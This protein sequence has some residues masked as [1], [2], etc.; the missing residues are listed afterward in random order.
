MQIG[1]IKLHR[2]IL[3][4]SWS[5]QPDFVAVWVYC[6][7]RGN[8]KSTDVVTKGGG[9]V[10]LEP[11]QFIT[12]REQISLGTGVQES[13]VERVL[14]VFKSEQQIEQRNCG[15]YRVISILNWSKYQQ[16]EQEFEQCLNNERTMNEQCLNTDKKVKKVE[17]EKKESKTLP[18][19]ALRLSE[20]LA[21]L[22]QSNHAGNS[23]LTPSKRESTMA[24]WADSIDK[25][26]RIDGRDW[27]DIE[28]VIEWCQ[29]DSFWSL[30]IMS[31]VTLRKQFDKLSAK[32]S[33]QTN[34]AKPYSGPNNIFAGGY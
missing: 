25:I 32:F 16:N 34:T 11:G 5:R 10:H 23:E 30:N 17:K 2:C 8:Y 31:G 9:I 21:G 27:A 13:K 6:L 1:Y 24:R 33:A 4:S 20:L 15:Y 3:D 29:Q 12:S 19:E 18:P 28:S 14:K 7:L 26:N 22:I